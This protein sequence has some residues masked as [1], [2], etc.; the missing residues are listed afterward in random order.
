MS[1]FAAAD[2]LGDDHNEHHQEDAILHRVLGVL[3]PLK[4][5]A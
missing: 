4:K 2:H 1:S 3:V 5:N